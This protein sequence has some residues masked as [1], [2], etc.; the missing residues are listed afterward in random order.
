MSRPN[1][2]SLSM[3]Y[4]CIGF[5]LLLLVCDPSYAEKVWTNSLS[6]LWRDGTNWTGHTAPDINSFIEITN[7]LTKTVTI[8]S[9]TDP[10]NLTVQ[11]L[12]LNAPPGA[13]NK[14]GRAHV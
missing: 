8:D 14:I 4:S 12:R 1:D 5:S 10:T 6:G 7:D 2:L 3:K 13:T 11:K 9:L